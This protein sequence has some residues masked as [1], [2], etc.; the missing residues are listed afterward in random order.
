VA[1]TAAALPAFRAYDAH[2]ERAPRDPGGRG[3]LLP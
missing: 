3:A 1:G 2:R